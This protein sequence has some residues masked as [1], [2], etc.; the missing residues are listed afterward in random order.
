[1]LATGVAA[2]IE[3]WGFPQ[4]WNETMLPASRFYFGD[5]RAFLGFATALSAGEPFDNGL[6]FHPPGWPFVLSLVFRACG[7]SAEVPPDH[8]LLKHVTAVISGVAVAL[9]ALLAHRL[10]GRSTMIATSLL[11]TFHFGHLVQAAAPNSE[12]L[13]GLLLVLLLLGALRAA[14]PGWVLGGV[15]GFATL[16][17]AEFALC[18]VLVA[19]WLWFS[20][21]DRRRRRTALFVVGLVLTLLPTTIRHW[22]S[23][24][25]FNRTRVDTMPGPL[26][27]LAPVTSYGAFNFANANHERAEGGFNWDLP[28]MAPSDDEAVRLLEA[29]AIDLS[30][31][32]V[33]RAYVD[34]YRMG[35]AWILSH[36]G[37][38]MALLGRKLAITLSVFDYGYLIDNVPVPVAGTRRPVDQ[39]DLDTSWLGVMHAVLAACG[40]WIAARHRRTL[41]L[42]LPVVTLVVSSLLFFGYVRLGVA[43]LPVLWVLQALAISRI[44]RAIPVGPRWQPRAERAALASLVVLLL[45]DQS[46][47]SRSRVLALDGFEDDRGQLVEDQPLVIKRIR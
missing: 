16:V 37:P 43:Y 34:G 40:L 30:R 19:A 9:A 12:P 45:A 41:V 35:I 23:I 42:I 13:Y 22:R 27:R 17:R 2:V 33:Y 7:W 31:A 32:P 14:T 39:I 47:V 20:G 38:A 15:A 6:P 46:A 28:S 1:V 24:D 26:P 5:T 4:A 11:G 29:G 25:A 18:A 36:P 8:L 3:R 44:L 21:D 10:G